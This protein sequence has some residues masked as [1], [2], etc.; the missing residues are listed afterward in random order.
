MVPLQFNSTT[1]GAVNRLEQDLSKKTDAAAAEGAANV[2]GYAQQAKELA[3]SA[4]NTVQ[5]CLRL[6]LF[7]LF[8]VQAC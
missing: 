7:F 2:Q 5:V 4:V 3:T 1:A 6:T 8:F